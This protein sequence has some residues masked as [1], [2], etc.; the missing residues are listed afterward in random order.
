MEREI[1]IQSASELKPAPAEVI[2]EYADKRE[3]L[4]AEVNRLMLGRAD[5]DALVGEK[6]IAMMK[7]NHNNHS[8]FVESVLHHPHSEVL[9]HTVEWVLRCY[10]SRGFQPDYWTA[11]LNAWLETI[12]K[13]LSPKSAEAICPLYHWFIMTVPALAGFS[14]PQTASAAR[15]D[16]NSQSSRIN[17]HLSLITDQLTDKSL[18]LVM[19]TFNTHGDLLYA[20]AGMKYLLDADSSDHPP[21]GYLVNP[22]F[23]TLIARAPSETPVFEGL[24]TA[25][26]RLDISRTILAKAWRSQDR[27]FISGEYDIMELER[28]S[29]HIVALNREISNLHRQGIREKKILEST[30][31]ELRKTQSMLIHSEKMNALGKLV[32]GIAHEINNPI[33]FVSS[34]L[35]S[36]KASFADIM[37]AYERLEELIRGQNHDG[38]TA[39]ARK[40]R[41]DFDIGFIFDDFEDLHRASADGV[42]RVIKIVQDLRTFSRLDEGEIKEADIA[43]SIRST[44]T[45]AEPE[46]RKRNIAVRLELA[47]L[48]RAEC[49]ASELNQVFLNLIVNA[50]QSMEDGGMLEIRGK[51]ADGNICLEFSD[52]GTGIPP[53]ILGRIFDPFFTTK[54]AG[55]GTGLGLSLA[56]KIINEKHRGSLTVTSALG[57]G[58][59]FTV[60]IPRRIR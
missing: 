32:A 8:L 38:M 25:G 19:G 49:Y 45:L 5:I 50:A 57:K 18:S 27:L 59:V 33:A 35:H 56:Y 36:L 55:T 17:D 34:N 46:L 48:P 7:D 1:L 15:E 21:A 9:V 39:A 26:N 40:I 20:N 60:C 22:D 53:D 43:E 28:V 44:L 14:D 31:N 2:A 47:A 29:S 42:N 11:Q 6:N 58:S 13:N 4:V 16:K 10:G 52:T 12:K 30:L 54:P 41:Q 23:Q 24:L 51:E 37:Q 3:Y